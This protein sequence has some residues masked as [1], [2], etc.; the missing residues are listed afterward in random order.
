MSGTTS[1]PACAC[2][3]LDIDG[4][5][6]PLHRTGFT[7]PEVRMARTHGPALLFRPHPPSTWSL[8]NAPGPPGH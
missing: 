7:T 4:F 3:A 1:G 8:F 6:H 2:H 5:T